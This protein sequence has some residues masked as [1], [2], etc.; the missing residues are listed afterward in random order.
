MRCNDGMYWDD[1]VIGCHFHAFLV[2][3][4]KFGGNDPSYW[5][6]LGSGGAVSRSQDRLIK[7]KI[8]VNTT[9]R[10]YSS[11]GVTVVNSPAHTYSVANP[12]PLTMSDLTID[13]ESF[14]VDRFLTSE[15]TTALGD[16]PNSGS[17]G[18]AARK[19]FTNTTDCYVRPTL[20]FEPLDCSH[21]VVLASSTISNFHLCGMTALAINS[22]SNIT[23]TGNSCTGGHGISLSYSQRDLIQASSDLGRHRCLGL[24]Y[25][26]YQ[27]TKHFEL[28]PSTTQRAHWLMSYPSTLGTPGDGAKIFVRIFVTSYSAYNSRLLPRRASR[29][30]NF[31]SGTSDIAVTSGTWD[32]SS[33][34][35]SGGKA[36][37]ITGFNGIIGF[38]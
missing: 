17:N 28:E 3:G 18:Q 21:T 37:P 22:G 2:N 32:W 33:L 11:K 38:S 35:V 19:V 6:D 30:I 16:Q 1:T 26:I 31:T 27:A 20:A 10:A 34:R 14:L 23:F 25:F 29:G 9:G 15:T 7:V 5:D 4:H 12:A 24:N 36:G 8:F 13:D